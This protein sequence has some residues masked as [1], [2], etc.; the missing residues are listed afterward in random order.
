MKTRRMGRVLVSLLAWG[1]DFV[2][3]TW[4][5]LRG[6]PRLSV[7]VVL[8][9][10]AV[11]DSERNAFARQM[12]WLS[13]NARPCRLDEVAVSVEADR[14]AV[15][16]DDGLLSFR[17]HALPELRQWSIPC[18]VF[19]PSGYL[20]RRADWEVD[21]G[22]R[23]DGERV[24]T[25]EELRD[26]PADLV[27]IGSHSVTHPR[28]T[29]LVIG[30]ARDQFAGSK[31]VLEEALGRTVRRF[32]FPYG[33]YDGALCSAGR[34]AGY[35]GLYASTLF[36]EHHEDAGD[37]VGRVPVSPDDWHIEFVLKVRG[38]YWWLPKLSQWK[39]N[40]LNLF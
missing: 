22:Y 29:E 17:K 32:S 14:V 19:V 3:R 26:L 38:H 40:V 12:Q 39:R 20:G 34:G 23:L 33:A 16:F 31:R 4:S 36:P 5:R 30:E 18:T 24:M 21:R 37:I 25:A 9:Y 1:I 13:Q 15:T 28:M 6:Q 27:E 2:P 8:C 10:H 7:P 11:A 35:E